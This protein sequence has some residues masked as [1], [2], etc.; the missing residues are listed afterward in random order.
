MKFRGT[1]LV[2]RIIFLYNRIHLAVP[3]EKIPDDGFRHFSLATLR[4][5]YVEEF[6]LPLSL[7]LP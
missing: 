3:R 4:K 1:K 7:Q 5:S 2:T 6:T